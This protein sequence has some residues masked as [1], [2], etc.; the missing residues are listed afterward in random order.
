MTPDE[1]SHRLEYFAD[2][3]DNAPRCSAATAARIEDTVKS[4]TLA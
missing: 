1:N 2:S 3:R 4:V